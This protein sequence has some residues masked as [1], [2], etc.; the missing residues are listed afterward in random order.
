MNRNII[1][2][3]SNWASEDYVCP[4]G[5]DIL[6]FLCQWFGVAFDTDAVFEEVHTYDLVRLN[7]R[8]QQM[9]GFKFNKDELY[10]LNKD[11][12][13]VLECDKIEASQIVQHYLEDCGFEVINPLLE[14]E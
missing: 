14:F 5:V 8:V 12:W 1:L 4:S 3:T 2:L 6:G 13:K 7:K 11:F 9:H 10:L